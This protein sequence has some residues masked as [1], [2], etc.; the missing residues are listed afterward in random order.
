MVVSVAELLAEKNSVISFSDT[1]SLILDN[2]D[3]LSFHDAVQFIYRNFNLVN[4]DSSISLVSCSYNRVQ[5]VFESD[6]V[7]SDAFATLEYLT[8]SGWISGIGNED[9]GA[10][11]SIFNNEG[12]ENGSRSEFH[13]RKEQLKQVLSAAGISYQFDDQCDIVA[14]VDDKSFDKKLDGYKLEISNLLDENSKLKREVYSLKSHEPKYLG[15]F[16]SDDPLLIAIKIRN[17]EWASYDE[18]N[19]RLSTPSADYVIEKLKEQHGMSHALASAIERVACP[20]VR[21]SS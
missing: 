4:P 8:S 14:E 9:D 5:G 11:F 21:K 18:N 17:T 13:F 12:Y 7:S 3:F 6:E 20:I 10:Y 19:V 16:R 15:V 2:N 1:I